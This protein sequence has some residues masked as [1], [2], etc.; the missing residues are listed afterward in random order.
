MNLNLI[1]LERE[2]YNTLDF[3]GDVGG[4]QAAL[5]FVLGG[6]YGLFTV[7]SFDNWLV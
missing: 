3:F 5:L 6:L 2:V 1:T 4:L 7:N